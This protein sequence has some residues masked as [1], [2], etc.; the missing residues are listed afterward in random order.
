VIPEL[1]YPNIGDAIDWL[2]KAF[3]FTLRIRI[4]ARRSQLNVGDGGAVVLIEDSADVSLRAAVMVRVEDV[5]THYDR[6]KRSGVRILRSWP[7][8]RGS[9]SGTTFQIHTC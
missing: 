8:L 5:K 9:F 4:A 3:G 6:A 7:F 2:C 1:A